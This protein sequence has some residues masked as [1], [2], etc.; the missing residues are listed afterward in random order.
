MERYK[1]ISFLQNIA[2]TKRNYMTDMIHIIATG[3]TFDKKYDEIEGALTFKT[4]HLPEI[5]KIVRCT[6]KYKL[7]FL[8]LKDSLFMDDSDRSMILHACRESTAKRI[9]II[10]G[11]D[12]MEITGRY[13]GSTDLKKTIILTGAMVPYSVSSSDAVF[14]LGTAIGYVEEKPLGVYISM[15]GRCFDW[16]NVHKNKEKGVFEKPGREGRSPS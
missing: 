9:I 8:P 1:I 5:M 2:Q 3:G 11:T 7:T 13:I 15:N 12:T 10:H 6:L 16:D 4:S 14:N